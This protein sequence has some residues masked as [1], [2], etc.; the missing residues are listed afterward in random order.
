MN[1]YDWVAAKNEEQAKIFYEQFIDREEIDEYFE[2]EVPLEDTMFLWEEDV[3]VNER[4]KFSRDEIGGKT[5]YYVPFSWV[6]THQKITEP[7]IIAS[8][9]W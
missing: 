8:T 5:V 3:P 2:G 6:I 9:E 1:E 4:H 7:C